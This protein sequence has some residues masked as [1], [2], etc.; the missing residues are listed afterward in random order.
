MKRKP[1][2]H[3]VS[4]DKFPKHARKIKGLQGCQVGQHVYIRKEARDAEA[5]KHHELYHV[6]KCHPLNPRKA[7]DY[8]SQE[9][10]ANLYAREKTGQHKHIKY[11]IIG[12]ATSASED[13][14][15]PIKKTV[16]MV[17]KEMKRN[18]VPREWK[19]DFNHVVKTQLYKGKRL[20]KD[21]Q[22]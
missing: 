12:I 8:I 3:V 6:K 4:Q 7:N 19:D 11:R 20:P 10:E 14:K 2:V 5:I 18:N 13:Y 22:L 17:A 16:R 9:I 1:I 21:V 15:M